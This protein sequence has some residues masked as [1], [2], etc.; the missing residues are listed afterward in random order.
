MLHDVVKLLSFWYSNQSVSVRWQNTLW[1]SFGIQNGTRQGSLWSPFLFTR[2]IR[3]VLSGIINSNIGSSIG[4][5]MVNVSVMGCTQLHFLEP[6]VKVNGDYYRNVV[7]K[8]MLLPDIRHGVLAIAL[9]FNRT[10]RQHI[11][12]TTLWH[13]CE[14]R[15]QTLSRLVFGN[16]Q[17]W[18]TKS[19]HQRSGSGVA[20]LGPVWP[21]MEDTSWRKPSEHVKLCWYCWIVSAKCLKLSNF[22]VIVFA[23]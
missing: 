15:R 16:G 18:I 13:C 1:E 8:E 22:I 12:H 7:L 9:L 3:E 20:V 21:L 19:L 2:Y 14:R 4:G 10:A 6:G 23:L 17:N 11:A 5:Y